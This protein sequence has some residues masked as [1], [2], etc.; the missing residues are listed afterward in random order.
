MSLYENFIVG[1]QF[2]GRSSPLVIE[3]SL[4]LRTLLCL[5]PAK[6]NILS[7]VLEYSDQKQ[8]LAH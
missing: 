7:L 8:Q 5:A 6:T 3:A 1:I 2:V 4:S